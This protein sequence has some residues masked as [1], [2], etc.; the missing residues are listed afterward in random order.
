[1]TVMGMSDGAESC[2]G[3]GHQDLMWEWALGT[4]QGNRHQGLHMGMRT[5]VPTQTAESSYGNGHQDPSLG[6]G[7]IIS[8]WEWVPKSH[9][10]PGI[11][12]PTW[13]WVPESPQ[14]AP[15][16]PYRSRSQDPHMGMAPSI[17]STRSGTRI[18]TW[19]W[20]PASQAN[21]TTARPGLQPHHIKP[22]NSSP[23]NPT[24]QEEEESRECSIPR[25]CEPRAAGFPGRHQQELLLSAHPQLIPP[26]DVA[27]SVRAGKIVALH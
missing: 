22:Q 1:M 2:Q 16:F 21:P 7:P 15:A 20:L 4:F 6:M 13:Q 3:N 25:E 5:R 26:G 12:I 17:P 11:N 18:P 23:H 9:P 8:I 19:E 10:A 14:R 24:E 27:G